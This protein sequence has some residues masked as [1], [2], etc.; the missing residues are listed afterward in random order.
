ML[1]GRQPLAC[2]ARYRDMVTSLAL[3]FTN[4]HLEIE[5]AILA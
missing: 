5:T 1:T 3:S 2:L 4:N